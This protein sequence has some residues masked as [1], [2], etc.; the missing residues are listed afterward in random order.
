MYRSLMFVTLIATA[1]ASGPLEAQGRGNGNRKETR[2]YVDARGREC[3]ETTHYRKNGK[4]KYDLKCK[5]SKHDGRRHDDDRDDREDRD[6][7]RAC[8]YRTNDGRC[9]V[10]HDRRY[11][12][13]RYPDTRYPD[14]RYP[15]TRYPDGRTPSAG[16]PRTLPD[17]VGAVI[18]GSG[19]RTPDV[20]RWLGDGGYTVRYADSDR[21]GRPERASWLDGAGRVVQQWVDTNGDGRADQVRLF[22]DG[23]LARVIGS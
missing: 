8:A 3:R 22:R 23:R 19:R 12:D 10:V 7:R 18:Y 6:E 2:T 14:T 20:S 11:P 13:T 1:A 4:D 21:N 9:E 5:A 17:M 16:Y 15:D